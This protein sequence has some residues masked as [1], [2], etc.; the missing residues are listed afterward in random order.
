MKKISFLTILFS[1]SCLVACSFQNNISKSSKN[2]PCAIDSL[3]IPSNLVPS[4]VFYETGTRT[5]YD[6]PAKVGIERIGTSYSSASSGGLIHQIYRFSTAM[7]ASDEFNT[8]ITYD[9]LDNDEQNWF[10]PP[11]ATN[12]TASKYKLACERIS[13]S[14]YCRLVAQYDIYISDLQINLIDLNYDDLENIILELDMRMVSC[15]NLLK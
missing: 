4:N 15:F 3:L 14:I 9:F 8:L 5:D 10:L 12:I 7:D 2:A 13:D 6:A 11:I 1:I